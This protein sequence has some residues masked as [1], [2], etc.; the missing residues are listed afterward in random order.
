MLVVGIVDNGWILI[1]WLAVGIVSRQQ[2]GTLPISIGSPSPL[3]LV[4]HR[5][6]CFLRMLIN[7]SCE[8]SHHNHFNQK[9]DRDHYNVCNPVPVTHC[10]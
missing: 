8:I 6:T 1:H 2:N 10:G 3:L 7:I 9:E 5:C 4:R